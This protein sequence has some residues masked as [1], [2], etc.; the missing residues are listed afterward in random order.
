MKEGAVQSLES[1]RLKTDF[2][3]LMAFQ[4]AFVDLV[5]SQ[6]RFGGLSVVGKLRTSDCFFFSM[7]NEK[8][9]VIQKT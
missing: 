2:V 8:T 3:T 4:E 9:A 5:A 6:K 7:M 1:M